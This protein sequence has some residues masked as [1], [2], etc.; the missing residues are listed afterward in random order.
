MHCESGFLAI[1]GTIKQ[2]DVRSFVFVPGPPLGPCHGPAGK[3][4]V[5]PDPPAGSGNDLRSL[6]IVPL[7]QWE[8]PSSAKRVISETQGV[9]WYLNKF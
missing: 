6:R 2:Q 1:F 8:L 7:A 3:L 5:P 4:T 9:I